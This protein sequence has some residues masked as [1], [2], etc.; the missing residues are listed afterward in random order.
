MCT[1]AH[2][3]TFYRTLKLEQRDGNKE[4][5]NILN[6]KNKGADLPCPHFTDS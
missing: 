5:L 1:C 6:T 3:E 2:F 4:E